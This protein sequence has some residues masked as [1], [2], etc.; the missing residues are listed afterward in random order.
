MKVYLAAPYVQRDTI[1]RYAKELRDGG[2]VVTSSWLE[3]PHDPKIQMTDLTHEQHQAYAVQDVKDVMAADILVLFTDPTKTIIR[4]GRHVEF[5]MFIGRRA[6]EKKGLPIFVV[7][8]EFEN[9]F[10][11]LPQVMHFK[12]WHVLAD[13]LIML[14]TDEMANA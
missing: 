13:L 8:T 9:I 5:G 12:S 2:V 3:E 11:H 7:G 1:R 10:H 4:A 14:A 6:A